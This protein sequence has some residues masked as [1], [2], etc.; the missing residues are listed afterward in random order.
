MRRTIAAL[1]LVALMAVFTAG[2]T[3]QPPEKDEKE[4][5][6]PPP[7]GKL[8]P[9][10]V[11]ESLELSEEQ[12]GKIADLEAEIKGK[13][14]KILTPE[15]MRKLETMRPRGQGKGDGEQGGK[16]DKQG[17]K[18]GK[19]GKDG[20]KKGDKKGDKGGEKGDKK[21]DKG[22]K[23]GGDEKGRQ[24]RPPTDDTASNGE[25]VQW[26][27]TLERGLAEAKRTGKPILFLTAAPHCG[28]VSGIW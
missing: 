13:L 8:F 28:G 18:G 21:G 24:E 27:A 17:D 10:D 15:Q 19:G 12:R 14:E 26:F 6:G 11:A 16:G 2:A 22:D 7:V 3:S 20:M 25:A 4:K 5:K 23:K 9:R 1:S